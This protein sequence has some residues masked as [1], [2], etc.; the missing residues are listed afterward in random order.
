M[1]LS[2]AGLGDT[3]GQM[4]NA[5]VSWTGTDRRSWRLSGYPATALRC[6]SIGAES[7]LTL[8]R[9]VLKPC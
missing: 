3:D 1:P 8:K 9:Q 5:S 6:F 4:G 7:W 2:G